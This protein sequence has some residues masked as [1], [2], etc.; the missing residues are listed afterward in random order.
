MF[1]HVINLGDNKECIPAIHF[2]L[3]KVIL[4]RH[5]KHLSSIAKWSV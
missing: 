1:I 4:Q 5:A 3:V 2:T